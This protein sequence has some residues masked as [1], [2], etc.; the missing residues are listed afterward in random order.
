M[1][2]MFI[3]ILFCSIS[4]ISCQNVI[5]PCEYGTPTALF[6][7]DNPGVSRHEFE[8]NRQNSFEK[9]RLD[10]LF[11]LS[12]PD[13]AIK[14]FMPIQ[15]QILQS[16]CHELTQEFRIEFFDEIMKMP[17][18]FSAAD[19]TNII[20][21]IF[22]KL[23]ALDAKALAFAGLA[24]ALIEKQNNVQYGSFTELRDGFKVKIDKMHS[25]ESTIVTL[26]L[27]NSVK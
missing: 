1:K 7:P 26:I 3:L 13:V 16:G 5:K 20:A 14:L 25:S 9:L 18:N 19:L 10:S 4:V 27:N 17:E 11:E 2:L 6:S 22:V 24:E 15:L 23:S 8:V 21:Q 12:D